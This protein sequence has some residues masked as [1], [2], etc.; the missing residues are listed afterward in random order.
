[1]TIAD[2]ACA[3]GWTVPES[4]YE[5]VSYSGFDSDYKISMDTSTG[6]FYEYEGRLYRQVFSSRSRSDVFCT[7][8]ADCVNTLF[9]DYDL[10]YGQDYHLLRVYNGGGYGFCV[11]AYALIDDDSTDGSAID[12]MTMY[13]GS[14]Y[15][16]L[17]DTNTAGIF[18]QGAGD[19]FTVSDVTVWGFARGSG[20]SEAA[21]FYGIGSQIHVDGGTNAKIIK[22]DI[23]T[24]TTD[25]TLRNCHIL[26]GTNAVYATA[27]GILRIDGGEI[28]SCSSLGHGPYCSLGGQILLNTGGTNIIGADG[29]INTDTVSLTAGARPDASLAGIE[30]NDEV[31]SYHQGVFEEHDEDVTL[32]VTAADAGT[33]LATDTGGGV[34]AANNILTKTYGLRSAGVYSIGANESW[35]Y[36]YNSR[37]VSF[38]DAALCSAA[39]GYIFAY[40]CELQG[41]MGLKARSSGASDLENAGI[42]VYNS[43]IAAVY[44]EEDMASAYD[45][46]EPQTFFD[47]YAAL[48]GTDDVDVVLDY[49]TNNISM[50]TKQ[51]N[52]FADPANKPS[53]TS[54]CLSWWFVDRSLTPGFSGGNKLTCIYVTGAQAPVE[55]DSTKLVNDN[56]T[57]Y[58]PDSEWWAAH[59]G[60]TD[61][62]SGVDYAPAENLLVSVENGSVTGS[63]GPGSANV[64]FYH[65]NSSTKWDLTGASDETCELNGDFFLGQ[66]EGSE[67]NALNVRFIDSE[68]T[69][70]VTFGDE[71]R[72]GVVSLRL[73]ENSRWTVTASTKIDRLSLAD[74]AAVTVPDGYSLAVTVNGEPV[75][76]KAGEYDGEILLTVSA[77]DGTD[78]D[79]TY[80]INADANGTSASPAGSGEMGGASGGSGEAK[81]TVSVTEEHARSGKFSDEEYDAFEEAVSSGTAGMPSDVPG[82]AELMTKSLDDFE[83]L[84]EAKAWVDTQTTPG[85]GGGDGSGEAS[86]GVTGTGGNGSFVAGVL[87][88]TQINSFAV[89]VMENVSQDEIIG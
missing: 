10:V 23:L 74:G 51:L 69:G 40:N 46:A 30:R 49:V 48:A 52:M 62:L 28:F 87:D 3:E 71:T 60:Q 31:A 21:N 20:P 44:D 82:Y 64:Y 36:L 25:L 89:A 63:D 2:G 50:E 88:W 39:S 55:V 66:A 22:S 6:L 1:M 13:T 84:D 29:A 12:G 32:V 76:L 14:D 11:F 45:F 34:I 53:V 83:S 72:S 35:V 47:Y 57:L 37:C 56:Y 15:Y 75:E 7:S 78:T 17:A 79:P 68:W 27:Q 54:Q 9:A 42:H 77:A 65:E 61:P 67:V 24:D 33:A 59:E 58:G 70:R 5:L 86:G 73:D 26:G 16:E 81:T 4:W 85:M 38:Q 43:R 18:A 80:G 8:K 19:T 41:V